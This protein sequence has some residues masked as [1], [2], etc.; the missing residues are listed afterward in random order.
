MKLEWRKRMIA[1]AIYTFVA[2][3]VA[4]LNRESLY[5][6]DAMVKFACIAAVPLLFLS[7][8]YLWDKS[9]PDTGV[10]WKK[11]L[12]IGFT[13]VISLAAVWLTF[14]ALFIS[15]SVW[16]TPINNVRKYDYIAGKWNS[17]FTAHFPRPVPT[18]AQAVRFYYDP[19]ALQAATIF[20][21]GYTTTPARID[22]LY[23]DYAP[24]STLTFPARTEDGYVEPTNCVAERAEDDWMF[25]EDY[26]LFYLDEKPPTAEK[27]WNHP[28]SHGV[29]ISKKRCRVVYW[30]WRG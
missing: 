18:D 7:G 15:F 24:R 3:T 22:S 25:S 13:V 5:Y 30:A 2:I 10:R 26:T 1:T 12:A 14:S 23:R 8:Y 6:L 19:G 17:P 16:M 20:E 4:W 28:D 9:H 11:G 21:L 29:A 27:D